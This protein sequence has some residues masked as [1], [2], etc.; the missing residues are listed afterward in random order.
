MI[1]KKILSF[2]LIASLAFP[3]AGF[4]ATAAQTAQ[5]PAVNTIDVTSPELQGQSLSAKK[6]IVEA[7]LR[8]MNTRL[9]KLSAQ[10]Q[11]TINQ[12]TANGINT[13]NSQASLLNANK[14]LAKAKLDIDAFAGIT[15][16]S[17]KSQSVTLSTLKYTANTAE[18]TLQEAKTRIIESLNSLK[19]SLTAPDAELGQ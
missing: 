17:T 18:N 6:K 3:A 12:L 7:A 5:T 15:V 16:S 1:M 8:D 11:L 4:A 13:D 19:A 2:I 14:S 9:N 10:T